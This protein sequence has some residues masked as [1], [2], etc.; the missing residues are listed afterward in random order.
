MAKKQQASLND[1]LIPQLMD[2]SWNQALLSSKQAFSHVCQLISVDILG[3]ISRHFFGKYNTTNR[4]LDQLGTRLTDLFACITDQV[5]F[6]DLFVHSA[7]RIILNVGAAISIVFATLHLC[8]QTILLSILICLQMIFNLCITI[9]KNI[10]CELILLKLIPNVIALCFSLP[11]CMISHA[12][13][14]QTS[15]HTGSI[16]DNLNSI[17]SPLFYLPYI[18]LGQ[19]GLELKFT[20]DQPDPQNLSQTEKLAF[21]REVPA[22]LSASKQSIIT[23]SKQV[24]DNTVFILHTPLL[25]VLTW[26]CSALLLTRGLVR[27]L[28]S[29]VAIC[30][31]PIQKVIFGEEHLPTTY[32]ALSTVL[33]PPSLPTKEISDK[34]KPK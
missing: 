33:N 18:L 15:K 32:L 8:L 20:K 14:K 26:L 6:K 5:I 31:P 12:G 27:V 19:Y 13:R 25:L 29:P 3:H 10:I 7:V 21:W 4:R 23:S 9:G 17:L 22:L 28:L 11:I 2:H 1:T 16:L 34:I 24:L 30:M